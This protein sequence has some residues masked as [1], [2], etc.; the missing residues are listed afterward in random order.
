MSNS[1]KIACLEMDYEAALDAKHYATGFRRFLLAL[2]AC[3]L[4]LDIYRLQRE[5]ARTLRNA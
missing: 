5:A 3:Q 4:A 1:A 2:Q